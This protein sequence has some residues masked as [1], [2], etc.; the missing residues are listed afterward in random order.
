MHATPDAISLL[1]PLV[2]FYSCRPL[3]GVRF[4]E[5]ARMPPAYRQLLDH[6]HD[7][8]S[9]LQRFHGEEI[10][11][12]VLESRQD[13]IRYQR[14]VLLVTRDTRRTVEFGA[15][16]FCLSPFQSTRSAK[17]S[18]PKC[19]WGRS[20]NP[21][22]STIPKPAAR[23]LSKSSRTSHECS[24]RFAEHANSLWPLLTRSPMRKDNSRRTLSRFCLRQSTP[25]KMSDREESVRRDCH[26]GRPRRAPPAPQC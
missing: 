21:S 8:T 15:I 12:H 5:A 11:V 3:P 6:S 22:A 10:R 23:V 14:E 4:I 16:E 19:R 25:R 26:R 1:K 9:T 24:A 13:D 17:F 20:C 18:A 2:D 7:M